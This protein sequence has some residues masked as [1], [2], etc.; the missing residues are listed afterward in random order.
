MIKAVPRGITT[1]VDAYLTPSIKQY[2]DKFKSGFQNQNALEKKVLFMR[3]DGGLTPVES[4]FGSRAVLSGPAGGVVGYAKATFDRLD[5]KQAC[6]GFD[7]GGTSTDVSRWNGH[8]EVIY[9]AKAAGV[10]LQVPQLDIRTVAAGGGSILS[11]RGG[12]MAVGPES[13]SAFPGPACY[14]RGGPATVTDANLILGRILPHLFPHIFGPNEDQPLDRDASYQRLSEL[15]KDI[16]DVERRNGRKEKSVEEVAEGFIQ[17]ANEA[18]CRPIRNLTQARGYDCRNHVLSVF[19]G[20]GGQHACAIASALSMNKV[21]LHKHAGS[22][23]SIFRFLISKFWPYFRIY[24][25]Y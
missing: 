22:E 19:G 3:S 21:S 10:S 17:V 4:F 24:R 1:V 13:A 14:R 8:A 11:F 23:L 16:N 5:V 7:M 15:T 9:E 6:I 18:M 12:I 20:A 25:E 2:V